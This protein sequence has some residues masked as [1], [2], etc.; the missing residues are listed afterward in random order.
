[1]TNTRWFSKPYV[2]LTL[3]AIVLAMMVATF[4]GSAH[5]YEDPLKIP[6]AAMRFCGVVVYWSDSYEAPDR[7]RI[8][9]RRPATP[10]PSFIPP[11]S[12]SRIRL[13]GNTWRP[14][15]PSR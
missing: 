6:T 9:L 15:R 11:L 10:V 13:R 8:F 12:C 7:V 14:S 5:G 4:P 2:I 1:M 3:A